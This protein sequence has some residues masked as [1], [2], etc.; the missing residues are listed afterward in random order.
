MV[1]NGSNCRKIIFNKIFNQYD[2]YQ[3]SGSL[4]ENKLIN[5]SNDINQ[6]NDVVSSCITESYKENNYKNSVFNR[7]H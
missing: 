6:I 5:Y 1:M 7:A 2:N 4:L 3:V